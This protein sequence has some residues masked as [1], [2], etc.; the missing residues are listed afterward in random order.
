MR[1]IVYGSE[2]TMGKILKK[3]ITAAGHDVFEIEPMDDK[4]TLAAVMAGRSADVLIDFSHPSQLSTILDYG[5]KTSTPLVLATTGYSAADQAAIRKTAHQIPI[6]QSA[7]MAYGVNIVKKM[8]EEFT[9]LLE[10]DYDIEITEAHHRNKIDAPSGTANL[11]AESIKAASE[12][13]YALITD[14]SRTN[15]KRSRKEIGIHTIRG[16]GIAGEHTVLFAGEEDL[17]EI[18]HT[19]LSKALFAKGALKAAA[20]IIRQSPGLKTMDDLIKERR[21]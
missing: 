6:F 5:V 4:K 14:R 9:R 16:G 21:G 11:L 1:V 8:L 12:K 15:E 2:G 20:Y 19:A 3:T 13:D 10:T 17:I 7:N 18:R